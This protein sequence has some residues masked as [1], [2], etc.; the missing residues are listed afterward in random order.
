MR[1]LPWA[2]PEKLTSEGLPIFLN[3][4]AEEVMSDTSNWHLLQPIEPQLYGEEK[5]FERVERRVAPGD[6]MYKG[7]DN[8]YLEV[9]ANALHLIR[10]AFEAD[11]RSA[12]QIER[13]LDYACG[14]GRV[15][16]WLR[17]A[18]PS[19]RIVAADTDARAVAA[20]QQLFDLDAVRLDRSLQENISQDFDLI[21]MGSLA[22]HL[23]QDQLKALFARLTSLLAW[24]GILVA[25]THGPYVVQRIATGERLYNL[26]QQG[27]AELLNEYK[28]SGYGF[29]PYPKQKHYGITVCTASKLMAI[30]EDAALRPI[31]YQ[32]R[33]WARHQDCIAAAKIMQRV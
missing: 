33:A 26:D 16:R 30:I 19:A 15:L 21:W 20:V 18:F 2:D 8:Q 27:V 14:F 12:A 28:R 22:T 13:I 5:I 9:G 6:G 24:G 7:N 10:L 25:T 31:F 1:H 3:R 29:S 23:P 32:E 4:A 17:A 11:N